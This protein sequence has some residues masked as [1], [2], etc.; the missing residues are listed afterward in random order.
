MI[1]C[2]YC[3]K[4]KQYESLGAPFME[5]SGNTIKVIRWYFCNCGHIFRTEQ[6]YHSVS[7]EEAELEE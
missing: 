1:K 6:F 5:E 7:G 2:P 4:I 3:S